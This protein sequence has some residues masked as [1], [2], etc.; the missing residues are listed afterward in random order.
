MIVAFPGL[1][2]I[3]LEF[4]LK[5]K[6]KHNDWLVA[7]TCFEFKNELKFYSLEAWSMCC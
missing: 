4:N 6:I 7:D 5:L 1:E 3:K 2:D